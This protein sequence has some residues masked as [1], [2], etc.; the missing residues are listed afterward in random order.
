MIGNNPVSLTTFDHI[1]RYVYSCC[2]DK[3]ADDVIGSIKLGNR[4]QVILIQKALD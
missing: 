4:F 3:A 1:I 2:I